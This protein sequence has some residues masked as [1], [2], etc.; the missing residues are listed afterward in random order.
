MICR[1]KKTSAIQIYDDD[2]SDICVM[3]IKRMHISSALLV[4]LHSGEVGFSMSHF[5]FTSHEKFNLNFLLDEDV[6]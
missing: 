5:Y 6:S 1:G 2:V 3:D 4:A